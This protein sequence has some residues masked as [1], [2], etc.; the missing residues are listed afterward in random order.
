MNLSVRATLFF[1]SFPFN[2][3]K[4][5][6]KSLLKRN[7]LFVQIRFS[8]F[9]L[10]RVETVNLVK[11]QHLASTFFLTSE[12]ALLPEI[13]AHCSHGNGTLGMK[14]NHNFVAGLI[15]RHERCQMKSLSKPL[16]ILFIARRSL[17]NLFPVAF[18]IWQSSSFGLSSPLIP[19]TCW[20]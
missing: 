19:L 1:L 9:F 13:P 14:R 6:M 18:M 12:H 15:W 8:F 16:L 4:E 3:K 20:H 10:V 7:L 11:E 2:K 17:G 5:T